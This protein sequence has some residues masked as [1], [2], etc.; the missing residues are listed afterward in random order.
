MEVDP[1]TFA[2]GSSSRQHHEVLYTLLRDNHI[3][4]KD[5]REKKI[6]KQLKDREFTLTLVI[7]PD[8]LQSVGMDSEFE[9]I[10]HNIGW[11]NAWEINELGCRLLTIEFLCTLQL[12]ENEVSFRL[13]NMPFSPSWKNFSTFLGF[14]ELCSVDIDSALNDFD[15]TRFWQDISKETVCHR[16][17]TDEI[18]HPTLRFIHKWLGIT[19]FPREN[20]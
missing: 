20:F 18:H 7:D 17:C 15:K 4:F 11:E 13:F 8:L 9:L 3:K 2:V 19:F 1:P 6:C 12:G 5:N 10:F 16:P 14:P